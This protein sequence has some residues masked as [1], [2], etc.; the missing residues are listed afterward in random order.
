MKL[1]FNITVYHGTDYKNILSIAMN[2]FDINTISCAT[3]NKEWA[4]GYGNV[5]ISFKY[6]F[7]ISVSI[8]TFR[9]DLEYLYRFVVDYCNNEL[10]TGVSGFKPKKINIEL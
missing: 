3:Q 4:K 1:I 7:E 8:K 10:P 6:P 9:E 5:L 2:G